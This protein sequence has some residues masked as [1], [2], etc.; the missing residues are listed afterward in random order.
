[1]EPELPSSSWIERL[2]YVGCFGIVGLFLILI[3]AWFFLVPH[4]PT[5]APPTSSLPPTDPVPSATRGK[6]WAACMVHMADDLDPTLCRHLA[7][8]AEEECWQNERAKIDA[9]C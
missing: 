8:H 5:S 9:A 2:T 6:C 3:M 4:G 7:P 1:M